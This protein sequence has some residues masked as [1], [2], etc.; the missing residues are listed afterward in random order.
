MPQAEDGISEFNLRAG[1][2]ADGELFAFC[3]RA[4]FDTSCV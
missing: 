3:V 1:D 2:I 4:L